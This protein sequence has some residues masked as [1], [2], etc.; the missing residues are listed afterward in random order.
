ME[1]PQSGLTRRAGYGA[2]MSFSVTSGHGKVNPGPTFVPRF[3]DGHAAGDMINGAA[4][5]S[6]TAQYTPT[7]HGVA[8]A[9]SSL[10]GKFL[11]EGDLVAF[12]TQNGVVNAHLGTILP[13][14]IKPL[15]A[16]VTPTPSSRHNN[17]MATVM[18]P[19]AFSGRC[20]VRCKGVAFVAG[21]RVYASVDGDA[22]TVTPTH[23][24][25]L[26]GYATVACMMSDT[27]LQLCLVP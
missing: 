14:M 25:H 7:T 26:L 9:K 3:M 2:A 24:E 6:G 19:V 18:W 16:D 22:I 27:F 4:D 11:H 20:V 17:R 13:C 21:A 15:A 1:T 8:V 10:T 5:E 23:T 12:T